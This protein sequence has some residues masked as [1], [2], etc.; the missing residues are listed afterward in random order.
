MKESKILCYVERGSYACTRA[1]PCGEG[2][3]H[4]GLKDQNVKG[5]W[6][7]FMVIDSL[8]IYKKRRKWKGR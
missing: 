4:I 8:N 2:E 7:L 1:C 6:D 3:V 5:V